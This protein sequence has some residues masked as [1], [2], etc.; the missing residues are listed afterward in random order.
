MK[1]G[2]VKIKGN[3]F[4]A[5][6]CDVTSLPFRLICKKYGASMMYTEMIF[7]DAYLFE[8]K[9]TIKRAKI[10]DIE[11]PV[12]VQLVGS[13]IEKLTK[14]AKKVELEIKPDLIDINFGC[15]AYNVIKTGSGSAIL[16][17]LK[18]LET[19]VLKLSNSIKIPLTC[20]MRILKED[21]L[22]LKAAKI[23]QDS[24]AK[25]LTIH[26]RT[27]RQGYSG[28]ANWKIIKKIKQ[29][30]KIPVILNGDILDEDSA[31]LAM[32]LGVDAIMIG[33][34]AIGNPFIFKK[35]NHYFKTG[36]KL[37]EPELSQKINVL[38]E[39]IKLCEEHDYIDIT[40]IKIL[41]N[42][43]VKGYSSSKEIKREIN[44]SKS[45]NKIQN[46]LLTYK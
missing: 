36:N 43:A 21:K 24:G 3:V 20:K 41:T 12:G 34:A 33:R 45:I 4:L 37:S 17:D 14:A 28:K 32:S 40:N 25:A 10:L 42:N 8:N 5:P 1:I 15:P 35:I 16:N 22:T 9:K 23:I 30:L 44:K 6:M 27:A 18:L 11:R 29:E 38:L 2:S 19:L 39:I 13:S 26:G 46:I 31:Q 7:A